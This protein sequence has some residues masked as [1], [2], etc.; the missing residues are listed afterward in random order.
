VLIGGRAPP[1]QPPTRFSKPS[2]PNVAMSDQKHRA[3]FYRER[4]EECRRLAQQSWTAQ[5]RR[6]FF[7]MAERYDELARRE[8]I[9]TGPALTAPPTASSE[10]DT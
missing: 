6:Q 4:A 1:G 7:E 5:L 3:R 2:F 10:T 8:E 9:Q